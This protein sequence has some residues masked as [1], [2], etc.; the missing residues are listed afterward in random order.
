M[1][2]RSHLDQLTSTHLGSLSK[3]VGFRFDL[4]PI[5]CKHKHFWIQSRVSTQKMGSDRNGSAPIRNRSCLNGVE[6]FRF[7]F[8]LI[9]ISARFIK[10]PDYANVL[11]NFKFIV[12]QDVDN[13]DMKQITD[14]YEMKEVGT[15]IMHSALRISSLLNSFDFT[16][17]CGKHYKS[18][19]S[20]AYFYNSLGISQAWPS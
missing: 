16:L 4:D 7:L 1:W 12:L 2:I 9:F 19:L 3:G 8:L 14:E 6:T 18:S 10:T 15:R 17:C 11:L 20:L 5:P 13:G